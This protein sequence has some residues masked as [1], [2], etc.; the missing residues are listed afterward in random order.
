MTSS[1]FMDILERIKPLDDTM[2]SFIWLHLHLK[3]SLKETL[4]PRHSKKEI[5]LIQ[6]C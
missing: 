5:Y 3:D 1:D 6:T 2:K 4:A